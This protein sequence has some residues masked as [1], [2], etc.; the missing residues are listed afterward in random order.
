MSRSSSRDKIVAA[1]ERL[2]AREGAA[3]LTLDAVAEEAGVSKGGLLYHFKTKNEL[4]EAILH[5]HISSK[6]EAV[7]EQRRL[8]EQENCT[9]IEAHLKALIK[10]L[11]GS[12]GDR[13]MGVALLAV[14]AN[15]PEL[16]SPFE[17]HFD[18][19]VNS[20]WGK[21]KDFDADAAILWLAAE[22]LRFLNLL[23]RNPFIGDQREQV[24]ARLLEHAREIKRKDG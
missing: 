21:K 20:I 5:E 22:G 13:E 16:L 17:Q 3:H 1:A 23:N 4:I 24:I 7:E 14:V 9:P 10:V 19:V 15:N 11:A 8:A 18:E 2:V 6:I 12:C